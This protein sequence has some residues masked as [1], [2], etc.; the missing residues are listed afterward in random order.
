MKNK[1]YLF[2]FII[3]LLYVFPIVLANVYY[4]DDMGRLSL[5]Y[6]WDGDGRIL[7]NVLTEALSFGNGIISIFPYSTLLSSV[8]LVISGIIVSDMLF[9]NK[10][11]KS[12]SSLFI[13]TSP[14][15]LENLSYRYD[16]ILMAVSVLCAVVPFIFRS[17]YKLFLPHLLFAC[18]FHFAY[19]RRQQWH[20]FLL[21]YVY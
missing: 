5:G 10:Y 20:I 18:L 9:E 1:N 2:L 21:R 16:S 11:L 19:I 12:I 6:G 8:I 13:L 3:G 15:M 4:V 17:H 7:S 14:F